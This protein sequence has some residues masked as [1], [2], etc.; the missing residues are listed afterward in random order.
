MRWRS[1][2]V[3]P[4]EGAGRGVVNLLVTQLTIFP[5]RLLSPGVL[6]REL[7]SSIGEESGAAGEK[8]PQDSSRASSASGPPLHAVY[9][10][11]GSTEGR[12]VLSYLHPLRDWDHL[13]FSLESGICPHFFFF[14]PKSG[15]PLGREG[16]TRSVKFPPRR[17][18]KGFLLLALNDPPRA[19]GGSESRGP[20]RGRSGCAAPPG[21]PALGA[22]RSARTSASEADDSASL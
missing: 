14:N 16:V 5:R 7:S 22:A 19:S 21:F 20:G 12:A 13:S 1:G 17:V 10:E 9:L 2:G 4:K 8:A 6:K 11:D 15:P 3:A 18:K